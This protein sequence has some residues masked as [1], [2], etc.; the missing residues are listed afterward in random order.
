MV[1]LGADCFFIEFVNS[2]HVVFERAGRLA[3]RMFSSAC[4]GRLA[5][6]IAH[7]TAGNIRIH[8]NAICAM[9]WPVGGLWDQYFDGLQAGFKIQPRECLASI[10]RFTMAG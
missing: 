1:D 6:G 10:E 9:L 7:V 4:C 3:A 8:R 2:S 5:P